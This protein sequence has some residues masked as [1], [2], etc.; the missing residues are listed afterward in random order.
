MRRVFIPIL[1]ALILSATQTVFAASPAPYIFQHKVHAPALSEEQTA[2]FT[3][4][5]LGFQDPITLRGPYQEVQSIFALPPDWQIDAP[6][7]FELKITSEFQSLMEAFTT[8]AFGIDLS[9]RSGTLTIKWNGTRIWEGELKDNGETT[10]RFTAP[11]SLMRMGAHENELT[12]SWD[13]AVACQYSITTLLSIDPSS[14]IIIPYS[15]REIE[16]KLDDFP[17]PFYA[18]HALVPYPIALVIPENPDEDDLSALMAVAA[19][20]GKQSA[21]NAAFDIFTTD[22]ISQE[23]QGSHH[24]MLIGRP[25]ALQDF[26]QNE[27][28]AI[29]PSLSVVQE[30]AGSGVLMIHPSPW[31]PAR[32]VLIVSGADGKSLRK[33]GA[34]IAADDFLPYA[35]SNLS[36]ISQSNDPMA[37][38]QLQIDQTLAG[39]TSDED[40]HV[41]A[42]GETTIGIPFQVPGD[43]EFNPESF[44][45]LYFRH[46]Q[47][48]NYLQSGLTLSINGKLIGTIRFSDQS[49]ENGLARIILP[50]NTIRPLKN[51]LEITY[52]IVPQDLCADERSG[53]YWVSIFPDS[54]LHLPPALSATQET[55]NY[56]LDDLPNAFLK[57]RSLSRLAL[58][59]EPDDLPSWKFAA[60]MAFILGNYTDANVLEPF[61][62][63][64]TSYSKETSALDVIMIGT[65]QELPFD[66]GINDLLPISFNEAGNLEN[67][68]LEEIQFEFSPDQQFGVL[69]M[70]NA[71]D[72]SATVFGIFANSQDGLS[73]AYETA[74]ERFLTPSEFAANVEYLDAENRS[75]PFYI[76][77]QPPM[78]ESTPE[79]QPG[80][81][82]R[83]FA[84]MNA[85]NPAVI[86]LGG[87]ILITVIFI[88]W[89]TRK[90]P[91]KGIEKE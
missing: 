52:T 64:P 18:D 7:Q 77:Q 67:M 51:T 79:D 85:E 58:V 19:G 89:A 74:R 12:I 48:I 53:N 14:R 1:L 78:P 16:L 57:D 15:H 69:Q 49:A 36:I 32:A 13:A 41:E 80:W 45:E 20:L 54:Y 46:S 62:L 17:K 33:A 2:T 76:E 88:F 28:E 71:F 68:P 47:L 63:F 27:M 43:L 22:E 60:D 10:V 66:S 72:S 90:T 38:A 9:A 87:M 25:D 39:L 4:S 75:H 61:A 82:P 31:N 5:E 30:S 65:T 73:N 50:P 91:G 56:Y 84:T 81:L 44:I 86:L 23:K 11:G 26:I 42:L 83:I 34:A 59:A 3:L 55:R 40:L 6:V 29:S 24:L 37:S 8:E 35:N 21:G 70:S